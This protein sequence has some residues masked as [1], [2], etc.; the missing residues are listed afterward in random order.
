MLIFFLWRKWVL[1]I[2]VFRVMNSIIH[3]RKTTFSC[4]MQQKSWSPGIRSSESDLN[5]STCSTLPAS[6]L[7]PFVPCCTMVQSTLDHKH[8]AGTVKMTVNVFWLAGEGFQIK[9]SDVYKKER[10]VLTWLNHSL[11]HSNNEIAAKSTSGVDIPALKCNH[12]YLWI[13]FVSITLKYVNYNRSG[14]VV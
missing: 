8:L 1:I 10:L 3:R 13:Y 7:W 9:Y 14:E 5:S 4:E 2:F 11:F 12:L 6:A